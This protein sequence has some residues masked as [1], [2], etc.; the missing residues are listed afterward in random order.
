[1]ILS[2]IK[3]WIYSIPIKIIL[4]QRLGEY[5]Q[6]QQLIEQMKKKD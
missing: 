4:L 6:N 2:K 5:Y 1:M 3:I